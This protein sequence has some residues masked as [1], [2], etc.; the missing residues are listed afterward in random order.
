MG[1]PYGE[2]A[3]LR[4][5]FQ[6]RARGTTRSRDRQ[7]RAAKRMDHA[8]GVD[9][10]ATR[11]FAAGIDVGAIFKRQPVDGDDSVDGRINRDGDDQV[12][13]LRAI[14]ITSVSGNGRS[15]A[16]VRARRPGAR[17]PD[18]RASSRRCGSVARPQT[19]PAQERAAEPVKSSS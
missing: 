13:I 5:F 17:S 18:A 3:T 4:Q 11:R 14:G 15:R 16:G 19:Q 6:A 7:G 1:P 2:A 8:S 9:P 10:T 12:T